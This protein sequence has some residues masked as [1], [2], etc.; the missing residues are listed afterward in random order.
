MSGVAARF[1]SAMAK[2]CGRNVH[3]NKLSEATQRKY[4][5]VL[6]C[7]KLGISR[8]VV[9]RRAYIKNVYPIQ[10]HFYCKLSY[11]HHSWKICLLQN[12]VQID[13]LT[14]YTVCSPATIS[15]HSPSQLIKSNKVQNNLIKVWLH[16]TLAVKQHNTVQTRLCSA[17]SSAC[18][19]YWSSVQLLQNSTDWPVWRFLEISL[20]LLAFYQA[21]Q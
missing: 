11:L 10:L 12:S 19:G 18:E 5:S 2:S 8:P 4:D 16:V 17:T 3:C 15:K 13:D 20:A 7:Y 6:A 21:E 9:D 1:L 14:C